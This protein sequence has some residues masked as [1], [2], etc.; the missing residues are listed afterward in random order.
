V[1]P[2]KTHLVIKCGA[3]PPLP[4]MIQQNFNELEIQIKS[5]SKRQNKKNKDDSAK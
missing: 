1:Q 5:S 2:S 4:Q 3:A